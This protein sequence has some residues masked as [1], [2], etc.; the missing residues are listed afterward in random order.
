MPRPDQAIGGQRW[1]L[2]TLEDQADNV[3]RQKGEIALEG[4]LPN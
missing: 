2:A 1:R 3:W 4:P